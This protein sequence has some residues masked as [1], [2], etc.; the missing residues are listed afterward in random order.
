MPSKQGKIVSL[1]GAQFGSEGKGKISQLISYGAHFSC[2]VGGTNAG[3]TVW[4]TEDPKDER[5][6]NSFG[7]A[8]NEDAEWAYYAMQSLP[9]G[10]VNPDCNL[11]IGA[12][13]VVDFDNIQS[14]VE[15]LESV[16]GSGFI[17]DRLYIDKQAAVILPEHREEEGG[18]KGEMHF[19]MGST[20]KGVGAARKHHISRSGDSLLVPLAEK[21]GFSKNL[22]DTVVL[23]NQSYDKGCNIVA[24]GTQGSGLS[25]VHGQYPYVTSACTNSTQ[26]LSDLG[27]AT[28]VNHDCIL[29][30][31]SMPIRVWGNSGDLH[32]EMD[33]EQ[34]AESAGR[35]VIEKTT[36]TKKVRRI[37]KWDDT[38]FAKAV[39]L[40]RPSMVALMFADY[41]DGGSNHHKRAWSE[42]G[43]EAQRLIASIENLHG[44]RVGLVSTGKLME[45]TIHIAGQ[46]RIWASK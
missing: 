1:I 35:K 16:Y 6:K 29:V 20:G 38:L 25:L 33:W 26:L 39:M 43:E 36:V 4:V 13:A 7:F 27:F 15:M 28:K 22:C 17:T 18:T 5:I 19:R 41:L 8:A 42:L 10:W 44:V 30:A 40:N 21:Y 2:R 11:V 46:E 37:G 23:L 34:V 14:E 45:D 3:H 31:R 24:E 12:G 32:G 9:C